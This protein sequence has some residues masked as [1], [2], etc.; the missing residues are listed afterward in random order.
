VTSLNN[1]Q[2]IKAVIGA[3]IDLETAYS[4]KIFFNTIGSSNISYSE[5]SILCDDRYSFL[6]KDKVSDF[7]NF[8]MIVFISL[9]L[10][11]ENPLLNSRIRKNFIKNPLTRT[12]SLGQAITYNNY[13][14]INL[15][16]S[17]KAL[18]SFMN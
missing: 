4:L 10:R 2:S 9:N 12:Y 13:P 11:I 5:G 6:L 7:E 14:V 18:L 3:R 1:Y 15:G 8:D 16:N 17:S